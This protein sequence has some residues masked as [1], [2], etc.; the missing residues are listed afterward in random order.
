MAPFTDGL[1]VLD[2]ISLTWHDVP[3]RRKDIKPGVHYA[4]YLGYGVN[5]YGNPGGSGMTRWVPTGEPDTVGLVR[6]RCPAWE[7][8]RDR[9][10]TTPRRVVCTWDEH[11]AAIE[12]R[13][14]HQVEKA[15]RAEQ[16][17]ADALHRMIGWRNAIREVFPDGCSHLPSWATN[18]RDL[19]GSG[20]V[21]L[22]QMAAIVAAAYETGRAS[23]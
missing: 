14:E 15:R 13:K 20:T 10:N 9:I 5:R 21:T 22:E 6:G 12:R 1:Q 8:G 3:M 2:N 18:P 7:D 16:E 23:R 19:R 4:V 17:E 11:L